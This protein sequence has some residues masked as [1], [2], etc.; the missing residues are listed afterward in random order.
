MNR[1]IHFVD[2]IVDAV[3]AAILAGTVVILTAAVWYRYVLNSS[4]GWTDEVGSYLL[5]WITFLG[6][7][8]CFRK[9]L[10]L[11][12]PMVVGMLNPTAQHWLGRAVAA[13]LAVFCAF[14]AWQSW[15]VTSMIGGA[16]I[17]SL[18]IP[19]GLFL[20]SMPVSFALMSLA[21]ALNAL[22][23]KEPGTSS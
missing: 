5:V 23:G 12:F 2:T 18:D 13:L 16:R 3:L 19:R 9:G 10:H 1:A 14:V 4:L 15:K 20:A 8:P 17:S 6:G 7:Y 21:L 11:D 22:R